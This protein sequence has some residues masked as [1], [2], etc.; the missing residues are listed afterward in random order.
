[1][2]AEELSKVATKKKDELKEAFNRWSGRFSEQSLNAAYSVIA[3]NWVVH[4]TKDS[5]LNNVWATFSIGIVFIFL[6]GNLAAS[7][8]LGKKLRERYIY[9]AENED[10]WQTE[11]K[12]DLQIKDVYTPWPYTNGLEALAKKHRF[13]GLILILGA[14]IF[15]IIS[16]FVGTAEPYSMHSLSLSLE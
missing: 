15:F 10:R 4:G 3:A 12:S 13:L 2:T 6:G 5:I 7:W 14:A 9:A 8:Y 11:C 1:M 16:L